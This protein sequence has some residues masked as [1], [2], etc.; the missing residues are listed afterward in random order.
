MGRIINIIESKNRIQIT[1][2]ILIIVVISIWISYNSD[3]KEYRYHISKKVSREPT[4][5]KTINILRT[6]FELYTEPHH[7]SETRIYDIPTATAYSSTDLS[8]DLVK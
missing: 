3:V 7:K 6:N 8:A 5:V 4:F 2:G 1:I